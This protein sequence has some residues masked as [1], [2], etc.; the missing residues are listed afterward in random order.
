VDEKRQKKQDKTINRNKVKWNSE[1][2]RQTHMQSSLVKE[3]WH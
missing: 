3:N 2:Q 1:F